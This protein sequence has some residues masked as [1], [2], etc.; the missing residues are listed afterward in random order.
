MKA[1]HGTENTPG[2]TNQKEQKLA[3]S[4]SLKVTCSK[5]FYASLSAWLLY[6]DRPKYCSLKTNAKALLL[7]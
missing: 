3:G 1:R 6:S 4:E 5:L 7:K 2:Q